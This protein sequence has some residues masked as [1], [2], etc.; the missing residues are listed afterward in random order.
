MMINESEPNHSDWHR[1]EETQRGI[2][3]TNDFPRVAEYSIHS[4][5][6]EKQDQIVVTKQRRISMVIQKA[7]A[8]SR[9]DDSLHRRVS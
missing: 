1:R 2:V 4:T 7:K 3:K 6:E 8:N 9:G 5:H